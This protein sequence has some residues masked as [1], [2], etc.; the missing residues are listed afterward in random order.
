[1][2]TGGLVIGERVQ[3]LRQAFNAREGVAPFKLPKRLTGSPPLISGPLKNL[4]VD[5]DQLAR[6]YYKE[7]QWD[8]KSAVPQPAAL[9]RLGLED[10]AQAL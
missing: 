10:V 3:T 6:H 8:E 9:K 4:S 5:A 2:G 7:L 1:M